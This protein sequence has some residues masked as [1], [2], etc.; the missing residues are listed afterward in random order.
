M[1]R[2][3]TPQ[4]KVLARAIGPRMNVDSIVVTDEATQRYNCLAWTLGI[5]TSW[6]WPWGDRDATKAEFDSFYLGQGFSPSGSGEVAALG[7]DSR[8]MTHG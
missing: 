8:S 3:L 4:E 2:S 7:I 6:I 5:T 1:S